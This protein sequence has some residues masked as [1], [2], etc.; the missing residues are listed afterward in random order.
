MSLQQLLFLC[1][2]V[3][4][5]LIGEESLT[6]MAMTPKDRESI[7]VDRLSPQQKKALET[8]LET[9]T[10]TVIA[11]ASSYHPSLS[12]AQWILA[13][14]AE[15]QRKIIDEEQPESVIHSIFRNRNGQTLELA[16][17]SIWDIVVFDQF[18]VSMWKRGENVTVS[19][20]KYDISRPYSIHNISRNEQAGAKQR[21]EASA[22]GKRPEDPPSYFANSLSVETIGPD[23]KTITL[24]NNKE[25][26][27]APLDQQRILNN[28]LEQ[29]RIRVTKSGDVL[30]PF[31]LENL[32]SG[33]SAI[34]K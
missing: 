29:D 28:W 18:A 16:N 11:N 10:K 30:Y 8:W 6:N 2:L 32:D 27:I 17:G 1:L 12:L 5:P 7:G 22:D 14:K 3:L 33:D 34:A 31:K 26:A 15:R 13:W 9:W 4:S 24:E 21:R 23:G 20:S 25:F 19:K